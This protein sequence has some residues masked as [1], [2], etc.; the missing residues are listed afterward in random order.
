MTPITDFGI[1]QRYSLQRLGRWLWICTG[2]IFCMIII[3]GITRLTGSGLSIVDW[4][5]ITGACPPLTTQAWQTLF[6]AYQQTPEYQHINYTMNLTDFKSI[7]WLEF[8]HR[9]WGRLIGLAFLVPLSIAWW[10]PHLRSIW[11]KKLLLIWLLGALQGVVGWYMV[12]SGLVNDPHISQYRLILHLLLGFATYGL[13]LWF[14][15]QVN[16]HL[17]QYQCT[18][19]QPSHL[20]YFLHQSRLQCSKIF[21]AILCAGYT[22]T[23]IYGGLVAGLKAGLIYN[24]FPTMEGHWIPREWLDLDP[25]WCNFFENHATVQWCHR[26]LAI[27]TVTIAALFHAKY[28]NQPVSKLIFAAFTAQAF[29]GIITLLLHVPVIMGVLHQIGALIVLSVLVYGINT[30]RSL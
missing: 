21:Y 26:V 2:L 15:L 28:R 24:T 6:N 4:Q 19:Y 14:A 5:P 17:Q 1:E 9:F 25:L 18:G 23:F 11:F 7:F 22:L 13:T 29:L 3:G 16:N 8:I 20:P 10:H 30:Q 27:S 12:K